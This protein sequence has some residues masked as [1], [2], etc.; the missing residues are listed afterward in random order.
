MAAQPEKEVS[1][2]ELLRHPASLALARYLEDL[3]SMLGFQAY[4][5]RMI[6]TV[7]YG[8]GDPAKFPKPGGDARPESA[9]AEM[10]IHSA[11]L[12][13]MAF[14]RAVNSF[15]TYLADLM[16]LIYDKYPKKLPLNK[17]TTYGFCIEHHLAGDLVSAFAEQTVMALTHQNLDALTKYFSKHLNIPLFSKETQTANASLCVDIRN[18]ITHNRGIINRFFIHRNPRFADDL[19]KRIMITDDESRNMLGDLGYCAR[20][21]DIRAINKFGL[22]TIEPIFENPDV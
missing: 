20:Q 15:L 22:A 7:D 1:G 13:E 2:F 3:R 12:N 16:S 10:D 19:G 18:I 14:C 4:L 17:Q 5:W 21:I 6:V 8:H 11:V 9:V